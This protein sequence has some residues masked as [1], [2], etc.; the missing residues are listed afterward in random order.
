MD[1]IFIELIKTHA[2]SL[3]SGSMT[4]GKFI[5]IYT[6]ALNKVDR[7]N[8]FRYKRPQF[9]SVGEDPKNNWLDYIIDMDSEEFNFIYHALSE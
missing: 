1:D 5:G 8:A 4:K 7:K 2:Y 3:R 9:I 6:E